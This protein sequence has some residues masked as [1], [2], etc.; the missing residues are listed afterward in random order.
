MRPLSTFRSVRLLAALLLLPACAVVAAEDEGPREGSSPQSPSSA[1]SILAPSSL[2]QGDPLLAWV[3]TRIPVGSVDPAGPEK[4]PGLP[5]LKL[6][7]AAGNIIFQTPCFS[8][9][10]LLP[11][12]FDFAKPESAASPIGTLAVRDSSHLQADF[13]LLGALLSLPYDM[14]PGAYTLLVGDSSVA[15]EVETRTFSSED[16]PL[17]G[18]NARLKSQPSKRQLLEARRLAALLSKVDAKAVFAEGSAFVFPVEG[19]F[20]SAGF[21]DVRRYLYPDGGSEPSVHAGI[22]WAVVK[23]TVVRA[24]GRGKVVFA[25]ERELT[26]KT[27]VLEHLPGLYS[28]YFHLS[29][30]EVK[31]GSVVGRGER[32]ALSGSTGLST[33]PHLHW[34]L[35]ARGQAV[36]P[37]YWLGPA[38]LDKE[39]IT[40]RITALIEGG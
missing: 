36:D 9:S 39:A 35:R 29:S 8:A 13:R 16:I 19:G 23:G 21:G 18:A 31:A 22:D 10:K 28:L 25:A 5:S 6:V 32:V 20:K 12:F 34:E 4:V 37:E 7:D 38:L 30:I 24:C 40:A 3:I 14:A 2:R 15:L 26:G 27:L 33:G 11:S 1:F 17:Q